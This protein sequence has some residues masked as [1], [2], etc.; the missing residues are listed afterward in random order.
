MKKKFLYSLCLLLASCAAN[1]LPELKEEKLPQGAIAQFRNPQEVLELAMEALQEYYP[2]TRTSRE[3][4]QKD[5]SFL[6]Y[7]KTR[8]SASD[9]LLYVVNLPDDGGFILVLGN[10]NFT[11][12]VLAVTEKG[13]LTD[14]ESIEIPGL[15]MYV[16]DAL[17]YAS[18]PA[19]P[20][21]PPTPNPPQ[22]PTSELR[23]YITYQKE[24]KVDPRV[25][26]KWSQR[27]HA[28]MY[29]PNQ[30]A[31][32][33]MIAGAQAL[34]YFKQP[35]YVDLTYPGKDKERVLFDWNEM[36]KIVPSTNISDPTTLEA[37]KDLGR[38]CREIGYSIQASY[39][40]TSTGASTSKLRTWII[41]HATQLSIS[42]YKYGFPDAMKELGEGIIVMRAE[43]IYSGDGHAFVVDGYSYIYS[44]YKE[45][46]RAA[47]ST[48]WEDTGVTGSTIDYKH[49]INWGWGGT[50]DGPFSMEWLNPSVP[51]STGYKYYHFRNDPAYFIIKKK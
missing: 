42:E 28:G 45:Q 29:C 2:T 9:S 47:G 40:P 33:V 13:N 20:P 26:V 1:D 15:K 46:I 51:S 27:Y 24:E 11:T 48:V 44:E 41:N 8:G 34:S 12:P 25:K 31:G 18:T 7:S 37:A 23:K 14:I 22:P 32:C 16:E 6:T 50:G 17:V 21:T 4:T 3:V 38:L 36:L 19:T 39:N 35:T 49:Y 30:I 10:R 5:V 43:D